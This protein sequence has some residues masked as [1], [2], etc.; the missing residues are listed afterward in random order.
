MLRKLR[1]EADVYDTTAMVLV[2][3]SSATDP[4]R[5]R[6]DEIPN[7]LQAS[8]FLS[9]LIQCVLDRTPIDMHVEVRQ[10]R[11]HRHIPLQESDTGEIL[12]TDP[13]DRTGGPKPRGDF[14]S[15]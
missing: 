5:M 1:A 8:A 6:T 13:A 7:D 12:L 3:W 14:R 9:T 15:M 4:V 2:D 11:E 10:R